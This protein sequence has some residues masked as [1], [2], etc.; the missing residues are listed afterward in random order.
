M[1]A[2]MAELVTET[3]DFSLKNI[4]TVVEADIAEKP[5]TIKPYEVG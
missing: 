5:A 2:E 3:V 4:F 1:S